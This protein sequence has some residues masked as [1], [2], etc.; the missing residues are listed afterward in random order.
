MYQR[1]VFSIGESLVEMHAE[2]KVKHTFSKGAKTFPSEEEI[3]SQNN[4][5]N[6]NKNSNDSNY[7]DQQTQQTEEILEGSLI[8]E[9][10]RLPYN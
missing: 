6:S 5:V 4:N 10:D 3:K 9:H 2:F 1:P 7:D 8:I